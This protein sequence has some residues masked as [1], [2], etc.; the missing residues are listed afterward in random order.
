MLPDVD[1]S[2]AKLNALNEKEINRIKT[3]NN[4]WEKF[5]FYCC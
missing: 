5:F 3:L 4:E 1:G 2:I